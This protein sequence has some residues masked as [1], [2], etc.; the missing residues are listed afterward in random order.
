MPGNGSARR[1]AQMRTM[2]PF[3]HREKVPE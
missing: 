3:S 2:L 1:E